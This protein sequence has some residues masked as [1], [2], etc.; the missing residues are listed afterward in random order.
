[1]L[2]GG[3]IYPLLQIPPLPHSVNGLI[4]AVF[5][6]EIFR[7]GPWALESACTQG[8]GGFAEALAVWR[9]Q[10]GNPPLLPPPKILL[11]FPFWGGFTIVLA[12]F[13]GG[14]LYFNACS[15][16]VSRVFA[17]FCGPKC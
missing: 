13:G 11:D 14:V 12:S 4:P 6:S 2:R 9:G 16:E 5:F 8:P 15:S 3:T 1:M 7:R 17:G 10:L